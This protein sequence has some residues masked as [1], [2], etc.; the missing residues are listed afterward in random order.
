MKKSA[1]Q[2]LDPW[3]EADLSEEA[4][5]RPCARHRNSRILHQVRDESGSQLKCG[6][7]LSTNYEVLS[8]RPSFMFPLCRRCYP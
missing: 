3:A 6:K 7:Q 5:N 8:D 4:L 1:N 2:L